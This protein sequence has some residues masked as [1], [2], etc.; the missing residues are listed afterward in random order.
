[1]PPKN[2]RPG[3]VSAV[4]AA[5]ACAPCRAFAPIKQHPVGL[6]VRLTVASALRTSP[7]WV[8]WE[9]AELAADDL[10]ATAAEFARTRA[11]AEAYTS[12]DD[13]GDAVHECDTFG[14]YL[15]PTKWLHLTAAAHAAIDR[16]HL[17]IWKDVWSRPHPAVDVA[18]R[19]TQ[20][21][22]RYYHDFML[23]PRTSATECPTD[24]PLV[25]VKVVPAS[26]GLEGFE[27]ALW[28][29]A[30][31]VLEHSRASWRAAPGGTP[32]ARRGEG[33]TAITFVAAAPE[34][35]A[36]AALTE[37]GGAIPAPSEF[38]PE[39]FRGFA[40]ATREKMELFSKAEGGPLSN[41]I[42]LTPFH[43]VWTAP[44]GTAGRGGV[45][46]GGGAARTFPY[47]CVAVSTEI[48][49]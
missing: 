36:A 22:M 5:S 49:A 33:C 1:M 35:V 23:E 30:E 48:A 37:G 28:E 31:D 2:T 7:R 15:G 8:P 14:D 4:L 45:V 21:C 13:E 42:E 26:Y 27:D 12:C 29:A 44:D 39:Q 47:P 24:R 10:R 46:L 34:A 32:R 20:D 25:R 18:D 6:V 38:E 41:A 19:V 43:P 9:V 40:A 3:L 17:Q 16:I 11:D